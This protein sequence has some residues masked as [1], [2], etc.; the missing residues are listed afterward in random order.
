MV[1]NGK[2]LGLHFFYSLVLTAIACG[3]LLHPIQPLVGAIYECSHIRLRRAGIPLIDRHV[4][5]RPRSLFS[6][7]VRLFPVA[8]PTDPSRFSTSLALKLVC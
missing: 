3:N 8:P 4:R 5:V 6:R 2:K 1:K 7:S